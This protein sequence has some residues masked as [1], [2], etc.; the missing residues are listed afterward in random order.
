MAAKDAWESRSLEWLHRVRE[1][2]YRQTRGLPVE[3]WL[4]PVDPREATRISRRLGLNIRLVP[5][6]K[7]RAVVPK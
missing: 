4:K 2:H 7:T 5:P 6:R 1:E 3:A